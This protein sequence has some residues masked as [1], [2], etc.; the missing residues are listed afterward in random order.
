MHHFVSSVLLEGEG[1][2]ARDVG[3]LE[4][5]ARMV[6]GWYLDRGEVG[7]ADRGAGEVDGDVLCA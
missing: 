1:V 6:A 4:G 7:E 3:C 2:G 5:G